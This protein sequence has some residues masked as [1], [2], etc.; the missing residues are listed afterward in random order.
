[1]MHVLPRGFMR[2]RYYGF[3][4][5]SH[6]EKQLAKIRQLLNLQEPLRTSQ[7]QQALRRAMCPPHF[8]KFR[9]VRRCISPPQSLAENVERQ[10]ESNSTPVSRRRKL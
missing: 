8:R 1:M 6:R 5:N 10:R 7:K 3:L 9:F 2:I 4:V